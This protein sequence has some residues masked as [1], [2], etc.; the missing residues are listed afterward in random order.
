[1]PTPT[2]T[3]PYIPRGDGPLRDWLE[4]FIL[5]LGE[6]PFASVLSPEKVQGLAN[7][8][9]RYAQAYARA[10]APGTRNQ[11]AVAA[12]NTIRRE[13]WDTVRPIA[14]RIKVD[15]G[16]GDEEKIR[17]GIHPPTR[18]QSPIP[19]P[20]SAPILAVVRLTRGMHRLKYQDAKNP[21]RFAKPPGVVQLE[22]RI[23]VGMRPVRSLRECGRVQFATRH[24]FNVKFAAE[25]AEKTATYF[26]RWVTE[27]GRTG[28]WSS[29]MSVTIV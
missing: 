7:L 11:Q 25:D 26:G 10:K 19:R 9:Q 6:S 3:G 22:L 2:H 27:R 21:T 24:V 14:M 13:V 18:S 5:V 17:L 20:H 1:M 4:N 23:G 29:A 15:P 28:P 8:A 16:I 12:K